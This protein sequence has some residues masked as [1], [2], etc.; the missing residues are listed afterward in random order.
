MKRQNKKLN[1]ML[2]LLKCNLFK[3]VREDEAKNC[4][5]TAFKQI[6][7]DRINNTKYIDALSKFIDIMNIK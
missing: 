2:K 1:K 5:N 3:A 6:S 7:Y 4:T